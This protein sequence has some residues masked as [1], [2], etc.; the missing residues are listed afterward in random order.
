MHL[1]GSNFTDATP[2]ALV[3]TNTGSVDT[4]GVIGSARSFNPANSDNIMLPGLMGTPAAITV[5]CWTNYTAPGTI[6]NS[7]AVSMGNCVMIRTQSAANAQGIYRYASGWR[8]ATSGVNVYQAGWKYIAYVC[9]P[10]GSRESMYIDGVLSGTAGTNNNALSYTGQGANTYIGMHGNAETTYNYG[11][12]I[13]EVRIEKTVRS[14]DWVLLNFA[15]QKPGATVVTLGATVIAIP[16]VPVLAAP[17]NGAVGV[18][19]TP[20]LVW[21]TVA[22]ATLY[23]VQVSTVSTFATTTTD[24]STLTS[25]TKA[26][27]GLANVTTYFWRAYA[28]NTMGTS[29]WS[30]VFSFTTIAA[31]GLLAP[32]L[33]APANAATNIA[34]APSLTWGTVSGALTYRVQLSTSSAFGTTVADDSTLTVGTKAITGLAYGTT[35]YWRANA[36][37]STVTSFWSNIFSFTTVPPAPVAPVLSAPANAATAISLVP[38]LSW[39]TVANAATYSVQVSTISTFATTIINDSTVT[40]GTKAISGLAN[41][42]TY[43][44][45]VNAKNASGTSAWST[46]FSFVT[47]SLPIPELA[48]PSNGATLGTRTPSLLWVPMVD[49]ISYRIQ[50][51]SVSTFATTIVNDSTNTTGAF[52]ITTSLTNGTYYWRVNTKS[53]AGT[54]PFSAPFSF[55]VSV[56]TG[57]VDAATHYVPTGMGHNGVLEVYLANGS[58]VMQISYSATATKA[59]LLNTALKSLS[60]GY[61]TYRFRGTDANSVIMGK[62]VK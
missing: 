9:N 39:G 2:N 11:G 18:T 53:A 12:A 52:S 41:L 10:A 32:T 48:T 45:R 43:Y 59:Q 7:E 20:A 57:I 36:K 42:S 51:S 44:W 40:T 31:G 33:T 27:T 23:R 19:T 4:A 15:T 62:L 38:T 60:K 25:G 3:G 50:V 58:R 13:D 55:I 22:G 21:G 54:S 56:T 16:A 37:N 30:T 35:Y 24:D 61:Y 34:L 46:V 49:A 14:A 5:S 6:G 8:T 29:D 47:M 28:K 1:S 26:L 17:L